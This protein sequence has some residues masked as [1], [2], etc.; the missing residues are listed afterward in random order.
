[1]KKEKRNIEKCTGAILEAERKRPRVILI[2]SCIMVFCILLSML[3]ILPVVWMLLSAFKDTKEFLQLPP[4]LFPKQID[5]GKAIRLWKRIGFT[6]SYLN[7]FTMVFGKVAFCLVCCG[8]GG[9]VLSRLKP[10]GTKIIT[11]IVLWSMMMPS[12]MGMVP[13]YSTFVKAG[14]MDSYLPMWLMAG[15]GSFNTLLFKSFFDGIS[16]SYIEAAWLDGGSQLTVF[17]KIMLPLSKPV[18]ASV[19]IFMVTGSWGEFIWPNLLIK[20]PEKYVL[21]VK[22][23]KYATVLTID[24]Y[25]MLLMFVSA[26]PIIFYIIFQKY[27]MKGVSVGGI[28]G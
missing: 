28:K 15:A 8:L 2:R 17:R 9:Y 4:T 20:T 27:I 14:M 6:R 12:N 16:K 13:L 22:V 25:L 11:L 5:F 19:S 10:K 23:Y 3:F 26:P 1:M 21:A 18:F 7:T 24:E